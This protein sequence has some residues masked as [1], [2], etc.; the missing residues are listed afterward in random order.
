MQT[1]AEMIEVSRITLPSNLTFLLDLSWI[2]QN[3]IFPHAQAAPP[4][5]SKASEII[6]GT[7]E[8]QI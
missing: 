6:G 5:T 1:W 4:H 7:D 3:L 2:I 8:S